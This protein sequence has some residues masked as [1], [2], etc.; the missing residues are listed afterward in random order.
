MSRFTKLR[1][2]NPNGKLA[3]FKA[4]T[5]AKGLA[6]ARV[7]KTPAKA[8]TVAPQAVIAAPK[9]FNPAKPKTVFTES[10]KTRL[11]AD[12]RID[13]EVNAA[14][15]RK[16]TRDNITTTWETAIIRVAGSIRVNGNH[17]RAS[18]WENAIAQV[19]G[20]AVQGNASPAAMQAGEL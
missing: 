4:L 2:L 8:P 15:E 13:R 18:V 12:A 3:K 20:G 7:A 19:T 5:G 9:A 1:A 11:A 10:L 6:T 17:G 16:R 14:I